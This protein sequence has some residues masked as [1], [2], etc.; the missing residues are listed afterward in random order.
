MFSRE[1]KSVSTAVEFIG[2][3][4]DSIA[5]MISPPSVE[6]ARLGG[7]NDR[8]AGLLT[9]CFGKS[10]CCRAKYDDDAGIGRV[11]EHKMLSILLSISRALE[12]LTERPVRICCFGCCDIEK[13]AHACIHGRFES[14][15]TRE[16]SLS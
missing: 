10:C 1:W 9:D 7:R 4:E 8:T 11:D 5:V 16:F 12:T 2:G 14:E 15:S 13:V 6:Y 3:G